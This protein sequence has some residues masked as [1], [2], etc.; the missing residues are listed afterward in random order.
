MKA[1]NY[2]KLYIANTICKDGLPPDFD[3][4]PSPPTVILN[5]TGSFRKGAISVNR[6]R[7]V[8]KVKRSISTLNFIII[9]T[10]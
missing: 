2:M 8:I 1:N 6:S 5:R 9:H 10:P 3:D 4:D 7:D